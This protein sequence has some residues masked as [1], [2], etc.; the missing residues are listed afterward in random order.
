MFVRLSTCTVTCRVWG[1]RMV[2]EGD[3]SRLVRDDE[4]F[5]TAAEVSAGMCS[6]QL[7]YWHCNPGVS[8][9]ETVS[10]GQPLSL[11]V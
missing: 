11:N 9:E 1:G 8:S 5:Y 10:E 4:P 2:G 7:R 3:A 6:G